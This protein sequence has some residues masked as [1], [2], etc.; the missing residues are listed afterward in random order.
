MDNLKNVRLQKRPV[1]ERP[2]FR[3]KNARIAFGSK[4]CYEACLA[5]GLSAEALALC[6][7][8]EYSYD[9]R[10]PLATEASC[11]QLVRY[12][13]SA[14]FAAGSCDTGA[15]CCACCCVTN[16]TPTITYKRTTAVGCQSA[17]VR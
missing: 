14:G 15:C 16:A 1:L 13:F 10:V 2:P 9:L 6:S 5:E 17:V 4:T 7:L 12:D 3:A 8:L 11:V